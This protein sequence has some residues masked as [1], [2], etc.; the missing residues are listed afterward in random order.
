MEHHVPTKRTRRGLGIVVLHIKNRS[1]LCKWLLKILSEDG[2]W[3]EFIQNKYLHSKS[4]SQVRARATDSPFW[5]GLMKV[6]DDF[7]DRGSFSV[8]NGESVCFW[9]DTW[10]GDTPLSRQYPSLY[11]IV[12][13]KEVTVASVLSQVID[14]IARYIYALAS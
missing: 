5:K 10:L 7:F 12:Q 11:N 13:R 9:K 4:L 8:G 3:N 1:M 14:D 2:V 6:K